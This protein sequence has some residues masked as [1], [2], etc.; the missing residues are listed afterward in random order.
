MSYAIVGVF[1]SLALVV[2]LVRRAFKRALPHP[3]WYIVARRGALADFACGHRSRRNAAFSCGRGEPKSLFIRK[4]PRWMANQVPCPDC[5]LEF[6]EAKARQDAA[7]FER[8]VPI[9]DALDEIS[10]RQK[11][12]PD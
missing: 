11:N 12:R 7:G 4:I 3:R 2:V 5:V 10:A 8:L 6:L 9:K 1:G